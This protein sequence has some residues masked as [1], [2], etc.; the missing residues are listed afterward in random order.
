MMNVQEF[1]HCYSARKSLLLVV[2]WHDF[3][4]FMAACATMNAVHYNQL[5]LDSGKSKEGENCIPAADIL[6]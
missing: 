1:S 2:A 4:D 6:I 3:W 5:L